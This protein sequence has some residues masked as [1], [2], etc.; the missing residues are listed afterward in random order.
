MKTATEIPNPNE[1]YFTGDARLYELSEPVEYSSYDR[2]T[3]EYDRLDTSHVIVSGAYVM[4]SGEET[5]IFPANE[6]DTVLDWSELPGSFQ[7]HID[8]TEALAGM[9]YTA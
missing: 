4:F 7:G 1:S 6:S 8:H 5:Y 3:G 9:G 2:E